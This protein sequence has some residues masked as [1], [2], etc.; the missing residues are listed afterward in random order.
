MD[1]E[2][3]PVTTDAQIPARPNAKISVKDFGPIASG[4]VDLRPLTVFVGPSNT[5]K[6]YFAILI[7]ALHRILDG[8]T[9]FPVM[10]PYRYHFGQPSRFGKSMEADAE[11]RDEELHGVFDKL[12]A[13]GRPFMFSDLPQGMRN[14]IQANLKNPELLGSSLRTELGSCFDLESVSDLVRQSASPDG[15]SVCL[16][17]SEEGQPLW[18]FGMEISDSGISVDGEIEDMLIFPDGRTASESQPYLAFR[19]FRESIKERL[20]LG[21]S[22]EREYLIGEFLADLLFVASA[23]GRGRTHYLPAARSGIMQSHRVIA[24]SLVARSTRAGLERFPVNPTLSG[25]TA[26]FM[27][28]LIQY[29]DE[30]SADELMKN[31]ADALEREVLDGKIRGNTAV[32]GGIPDFVYQ[33]RKTEENIR[34]TRASSMVTELAPVVLLLRNAIARGDM[35]IID[36]P[37]AHLHPAA[38]TEMAKTLG[39]LARA[40]VQV[41]VTTHSDWLLM[42]I[43]NLIREG[44]LEEKTGEPIGEQPLP[45]SLQSSDVGVWLF[46]DDET[47]AGST[48]KEIPY[49]RIEG[50][51]PREYEDVAEAL[52]NRSANLQN[53]LSETAKGGGYRDE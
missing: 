20:E 51:E 27:Q 3:N 5:G 37:E 25:V 1:K 47:S 50:V 33:P 41:I 17:V 32:A 44:E 14:V 52:Y 8:F 40:G 26:D 53:R 16:N 18:Q 43:G 30:H 15:M 46:R 39:R 28:R 2:I 13:E 31:L 11:I 48:V 24:S 12:A 42:E 45:S 9:R 29:E 38:Q 23:S 4:T 7:Y 21:S 34:L 6:T 49:D 35:L 19:R 36:E 22:G 10:Y